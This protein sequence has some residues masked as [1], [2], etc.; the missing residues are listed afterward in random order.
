MVPTR[1]ELICLSFCIKRASTQ[2]SLVS[3]LRL[4][5]SKYKFLI[6]TEAPTSGH[7]FYPKPGLLIVLAEMKNSRPSETYAFHRNEQINRVRL[8]APHHPQSRANL[9]WAKF[10]GLKVE[11]VI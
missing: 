1:K 4:T 2:C 9:W 7:P 5:Q 10:H 3:S 6:R 8:S 11:V